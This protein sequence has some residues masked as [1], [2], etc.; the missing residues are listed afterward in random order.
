[1]VIV[2][3][4]I[5]KNAILVNSCASPANFVSPLLLKYF[6]CSKYAS[7]NTKDNFVISSIPPCGILLIISD[8]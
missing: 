6:A 8:L 4:I 7:V 5:S 1:M 3:V 2:A